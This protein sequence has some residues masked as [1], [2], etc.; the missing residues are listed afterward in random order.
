[1]RLVT[2]E[3]PRLR[4]IA[5][6][7]ICPPFKPRTG[8][9]P[10][11]VEYGLSK[12][13]AVEIASNRA[14]VL[15]RQGLDGFLSSS[16]F[17]LLDT[18]QTGYVGA[19]EIRGFLERTGYITEDTEPKLIVKRLDRDG[20]GKLSYAEFVR[21]VL[22]A[23]S[24]FV[25]SDMR[26]EEETQLVTP[27]KKK[28]PGRTRSVGAPSTARTADTLHSPQVPAANE[29][30]YKT[31]EEKSAP[32]GEPYS[33]ATL[34]TSGVVKSAAMN[35]SFNRA[36]SSRGE[37]DDKNCH[38]DPAAR[39][40]GERLLADFMQEQVW[41]ERR[42]EGNRVDLAKHPDFTILEGFRLLDRLGKGFVELEDFLV[43]TDGQSLPQKLAS[44]Y[45]KR[46][47]MG[48]PR[49][50]RLTDFGKIVLPRTDEYARLLLNRIQSKGMAIA[51]QL[52]LE[53]LLR[54]CLRT[55]A[56]EEK[57]RIRLRAKEGFDAHA[58]FAR[59]DREKE[60]HVSL[61]SVSLGWEMRVDEAVHGEEW[62]EG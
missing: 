19:G 16:L 50:L 48:A 55:D 5:T 18:K 44:N 1:M 29:E 40:Q 34:W 57:L 2:P 25:R 47:A 35:D 60:G 43:F 30:A 15:K 32:Q 53:S 56:E 7:K 61:L 21:G 59:L 49:R 24:G 14:A 31:P 11:E 4:F 8:P 36:L 22:P 10:H 28:T 51:T 38:H 62:R 20:D 27:E 6:E 3:D 52:A 13:F 23:P 41:H 58:A 39:S 9:L 54:L 17:G 33:G 12:L 42:L 45:F 37:A 46:H 26:I